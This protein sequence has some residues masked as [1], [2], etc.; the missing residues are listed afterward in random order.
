MALLLSPPKGRSGA[1]LMVLELFRG[2]PLVGSEALLGVLLGL[3]EEF[4]G[5]VGELAE[6]GGVA[7]FA[8]DEGL[9]VS[10]WGL[11]IEGEL[12]LGGGIEPVGLPVAGLD[13]LGDLQA[14]RSS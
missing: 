3:G 7:V 2:Q 12:L 10:L 14:G 13:G 1:T 8:L 9:I 11:G 6:E 5:H 4:G